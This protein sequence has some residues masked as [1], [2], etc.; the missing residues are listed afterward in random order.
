MVGNGVMARKLHGAYKRQIDAD[1]VAFQIPLDVA[2]VGGIAHK[3]A[4]AIVNLGGTEPFAD[5]LRKP[6]GPPRC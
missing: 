2:P 5:A 3:A 4:L 6:F 1:A